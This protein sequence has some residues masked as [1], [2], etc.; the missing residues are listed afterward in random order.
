MQLGRLDE[1]IGAPLRIV[2][3]LR[4]AQEHLRQLGPARAVAEERVERRQRRQ[5][6]RVDVERGG[7]R[8]LGGVEMAELGALRLGD[9]IVRDRRAPPD[10]A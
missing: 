4:F 1:M 2:D 7:V 8:D 5:M 3:L 10:R 9:A 6:Q